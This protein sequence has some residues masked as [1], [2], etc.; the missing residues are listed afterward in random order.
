MTRVCFRVDNSWQKDEDGN[1]E[2]TAVFPDMLE[3]GGIYRT[4]YAHIGQHCSAHLDWINET[5]PAKPEEYAPLLA[6]LKA[7]GYDDLKVLQ[8]F[9]RKVQA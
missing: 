4:C 5:S 2:V 1:R 6:E 7:I 9:T 8:R 3:S